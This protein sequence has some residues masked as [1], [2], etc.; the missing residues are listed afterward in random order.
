[1][2]APIVKGKQYLLELEDLA[3]GGDAVGRVD[4]FAIFVPEGIPGEKVL[5][6]ITEVKKSFGRGRIIEVREP[7][8]ARKEPACPIFRECGGCQLKH[9]DY[10]VQLDYKRQMVSD[11]LARIGGIGL[12]VEP[13]IG[14]EFPHSYR[15]K[16]RYALE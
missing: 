12:Q 14:M 4:N 7:S 11:V 9:I 3:Y 10:R 1:M 6:E 13:V 15:N 5:V 2:T 8:P 16:A